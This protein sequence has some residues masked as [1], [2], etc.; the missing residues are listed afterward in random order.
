MRYELKGLKFGF[1]EVISEAKKRPEHQ[2]QLAWVCRCV[3]G[4]LHE[5]TSREIRTGHTKSCGCKKAELQAAANIVHGYA[6]RKWAIPEY[7]IWGEMI[8]RCCNEKSNRWSSY[9]GRGI[10]VCQRWKDSFEEFLKDMGRRP[11]KGLS[12]E[13]RDNDGGYTPEN[14]YWATKKEQQRNKRT[15]V[16]IEINGVT[17]PLVEWSEISGVPESTIRARMNRGN[18]GESLVREVKLASY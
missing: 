7:R 9:G 11:A 10:K 1:L 18:Y 16:R 13:R 17:R 5:A 4:N 14:C 2:G 3:C 8:Q 6:S 15:T 12:L